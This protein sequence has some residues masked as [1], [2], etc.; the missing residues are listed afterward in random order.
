LASQ[1][2]YTARVA[3][4]AAKRAEYE[5]AA[6]LAESNFRISDIY[7]ARTADD[8]LTFLQQ[9]RSTTDNLLVEDSEINREELIVSVAQHVKP[10]AD[11]MSQWVAQHRVTVTNGITTHW[12]VFTFTSSVADHGLFY[13]VVQQGYDRMWLHKVGGIGE[14]KSA[15]NGFG[16]NLVTSQSSDLGYRRVAVKQSGSVS[17]K[18]RS[19]CVFDYSLMHPAVLLELEWPS[20]QD[21]AVATATFRAS[22]NGAGG[23]RTPGYLGRPVAAQEWEV[24]IYGGAPQAGLPDWD[25]S[26]LED[27]ELVFDTTFA[28]REPGA[29]DP[30]DCVRVDF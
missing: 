20:G 19:G 18:A 5:L 23:T 29:P 6:R 21:P 22:V 10:S 9:L 16:I 7:R 26:D 24:V 27:I 15:S 11:T 3:Y 4:L 13:N 8:M 1:L 12:L 17:L 30:L 28:S 2:E 14:P 25:F